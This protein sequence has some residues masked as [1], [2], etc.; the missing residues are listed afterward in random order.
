MRAVDLHLRR[1]F[2]VLVAVVTLLRGLAHAAPGNFETANQ[3]Y[4][5]GKFSEA[6]RIY[7]QFVD[8]GK[9][10]ANLFYNLG[11]TDYRLGSTGRAI[12]NYERAVALD[13]SHPEARANLLL[14]RNQ[15]GARLRALPWWDA[16]VMGLP[17]VFWVAIGTSA[18]WV[19]IFSL[20]IVATCRRGEPRRGWLLA[21]LA[22]LVAVVS[23]GALWT[24]EQDRAMAI[25]TAQ[26]TE[27]RLAPADRA[28]LAEALP[29]G[30]RVRVLSERG[31]WVYCALPGEGRGWI[32]QRAIERVRL[33]S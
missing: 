30:S 16:T 1:S 6:K 12:L 18:A 14:L 25:V 20:A 8:D 32:P 7:E 31:D 9:W 11:N 22:A 21:T 19:A 33:G 4:D 27:A 15:A 23:G 26:S 3:L 17:A 28:A 10:N 5:Q 2:V 13:R 29:A 24:L